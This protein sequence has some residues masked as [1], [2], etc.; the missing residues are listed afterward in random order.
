MTGGWRLQ[1]G[2]ADPQDEDKGKRPCRRSE[3][4]G[5]MTVNRTKMIF[6]YDRIRKTY[7]LLASVKA[8]E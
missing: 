5:E 3:T 4:G 8:H 2:G 1:T 7:K 6:W